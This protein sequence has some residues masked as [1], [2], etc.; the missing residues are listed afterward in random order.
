M[1][2]RNI[3]D[4][5]EP[6]GTGL[7]Q[8]IKMCVYGRTGTG[9]TAFWSTFPK[10]ILALVCSGIKKSGEL[11]S[12]LTPKNRKD[13]KQ[14]HVSSKDKLIEIGRALQEANKFATIVLDHATGLQ[15]RILTE[16]LGLEELPAQGS[17]GMANRQQWQ[18]CSI[19]TKEAMRSLLNLS[20][21]TVIIA[22][23]REF[24]VD[25][26]NDLLM[27]YVGAALTP[28]TAGWLNQTCDYICQ[29]FIRQKTIQ[30]RTKI[31]KKAI[32]Q[33]VRGKGVEYCL[34]TAE[35]EVFMTRFRVPIERN[36]AL[37]E[38]I[39]NPTFQKVKELID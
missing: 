5:I 14:W 32:I 6:L 11:R 35:H 20:G 26:D 17:W 24:N 2:R 33:Q 7:E 36:V 10:P 22:Q 3:L 25:A 13:I 18:Q 27:P 12:I 37:P 15:D 31:G 23:E 8:G 4:E 1:K 29:T 28:S 9:K 16:I 38:L 19:Q 30:K 39:I 21:N 34:R